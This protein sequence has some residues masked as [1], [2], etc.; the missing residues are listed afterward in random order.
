MSPAPTDPSVPFSLNPTPAVNAT[1]AI[2]PSFQNS[3]A[4]LDFIF[5]PFSGIAGRVHA[6]GSKIKATA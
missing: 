4:P 2:V 3:T 6:V 5:V 1:A